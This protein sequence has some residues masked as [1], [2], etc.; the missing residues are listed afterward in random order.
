MR[1]THCCGSSGPWIRPIPPC[2]RPSG[3]A[4]L[5]SNPG[6]DLHRGARYLCE[7]GTRN[8][9]EGGRDGL[10]ADGRL[11][12]D[13]WW[14]TAIA[15]ATLGWRILAR[16]QRAIEGTRRELGGEIAG[17]RQEL[18]G[19]RRELGGGNRRYAPGTRWDTPRTRRGNRRYAPGRAV[20]LTRASAAGLT[21]F[22]KT[23]APTSPGSATTSAPISP[24]AGTDS[25]GCVRDSLS[26]GGK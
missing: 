14:A 1:W 17:M 2:R 21:W 24:Q 19:T 25:W 10:V 18:D 7:A 20:T 16:M 23:S 15:V 22:G 9:L 8:D 3:A 6:C 4:I 13:R 5:V 12:G 11:D 26:F